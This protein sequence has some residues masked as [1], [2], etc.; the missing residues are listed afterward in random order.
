MRRNFKGTDFRNRNL[1]TRREPVEYLKLRLARSRRLQR[2]LRQPVSRLDRIVERRF[3]SSTK[4]DRASGP[5][6][7]G[8]CADCRYRPPRLSDRS[9]R[10]LFQSQR[11]GS[12]GCL[13]APTRAKRIINT[14]KP[15]G[16]SCSLG[17][18]DS[19]AS[20]RRW[21]PGGAHSDATQPYKYGRNTGK[22]EEGSGLG[23]R[24]VEGLTF[25]IPLSSIREQEGENLVEGG[26]PTRLHRGRHPQR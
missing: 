18:A 15:L 9:G 19:W 11:C 17:D 16:Q 23:D 10:G 4:C 5:P 6:W 21:H 3:R 2:E 25:L 24:S 8:R 13:R 1:V 7:Q 14:V 20:S 12:G 22:R 26:P